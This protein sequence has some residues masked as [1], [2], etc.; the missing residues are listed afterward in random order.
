MI[1]AENIHK[2]YGKNEIL[3]GISLDIA[4]GELSVLRA[5]GNPRC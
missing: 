1:K 4:D 2:S 3:K 5:R